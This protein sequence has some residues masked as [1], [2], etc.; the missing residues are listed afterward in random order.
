MATQINEGRGSN[1]LS[2]IQM[3]EWAQSISPSSR[4]FDLNIETD[5]LVQKYKDKLAKLNSEIDFSV[6]EWW[7]FHKN[8]I[9]IHRTEGWYGIV[10]KRRG[11]AD[12][13][14]FYTVQTLERRKFLRPQDMVAVNREDIP[15]E[16]R[17]LQVIGRSVE[18]AE[19][20]LDKLFDL[21]TKAALELDKITP[22]T[23]PKE[24]SELI[25]QARA[26]IADL[27]TR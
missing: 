27:Q 4:D 18:K 12:D 24:L 7:R 26:I 20:P 11:D 13:D 21:V 15:F 10:E 9:F 25:F 3:W 6:Q 16:F 1:N 17:D 19:S 2:K 23:K 5:R 14:E 8:D 22:P